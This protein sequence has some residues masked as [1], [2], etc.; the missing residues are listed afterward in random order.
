MN[1]YI[2][3]VNNTLV[4]KLREKYKGRVCFNY[5]ALNGIAKYRIRAEVSVEDRNKLLQIQED[6]RYDEIRVRVIYK[7]WSLMKW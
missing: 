4:K 6:I 7:K 5:N 1:S 2:S 3:A